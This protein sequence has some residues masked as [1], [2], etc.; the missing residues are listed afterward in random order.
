M[1]NSHSPTRPLTSLD[2]MGEGWE[3]LLAS[4]SD[5][6]AGLQIGP[7]KLKRPLGEGGMGMVWLAEQ[8][9]PL[10]REVAIK[11]MRQERRGALDEAYFEVERQALARLSHR[12]IA[13]IH[14][15]GRLP[16][17]TLFFAMEYVPGVP[18][19]DFVRAERPALAELARLFVEICLGVQHAH[20]RG[21]IHRDLKPA[22]LL[23]QRVEGVAL[24][25][26]IDF[27]IATSLSPAGT[28]GSAT[29]A[30]TRAYMS[31]EQH[32][33]DSA[34]IDARTDV[35]A[36]GAVLAECLLLSAGIETAVETNSASLREALTLSLGP[37]RLAS[38]VKEL[39]ALPAE[40]RAIA[41]LAMS[42]DREKRYGSAAAMADDLTRWLARKPV[43]AMGASRWYSLRCLVR[44][45]AL[46]STAAIVALLA[47][48]VFA[49]AM[50]VQASRIAREAER[51]NK[52]LA[53]L[54][55]VTDFQN[56]QLLGISTEKVGTRIFNEIRAR[57]RA[58]LVARGLPT[59]SI[60]ATDAEFAA[61]L[62]TVNFTDV[63]R[64]SLDEGIFA[65]G[66][67]NIREKF[68]DQPIVR[69]ELLQ[70]SS[71]A[72]R[73]LGLL[74][75]ARV[76]QEEALALKRQVYTDPHAQIAYSLNE[77]GVLCQAE[78]KPA[79][80][81]AYFREAL[82]MNMAT[83][84][85]DSDAT[86][87]SMLNLAT[88]LQVQA[89]KAEE[90]EQLYRRMIAVQEK[91]L[92]ADDPGVLMARGNYAVM[93]YQAGDYVAAEREFL[94]VLAAHRLSG[95]E[96]LSL[97]A[98][99]NLSGTT[100]AT[101]KIVEAEAYLRE[102][103]AIGS[104]LLGAEHRQVLRYNVSLSTIMSEL[105]R[106]DEAEALLR[107][108]L[109][110][111][112]RTL[113][114]NHL[115][116]LR[117]ELLLGNLLARQDRLIEAELLVRHAYEQYRLQSGSDHPSTLGALADLAEF[118]R[119][120]GQAKAAVAMLRE[121]MADIRRV[122]TGADEARLGSALST[123]GQALASLDGDQNRADAQAMLEESYALF[124]RVRGE[125]HG[126]PRKIARH[127]TEF[128]LARE[129]AEPGAGHAATAAKWQAL[130]DI[131]ATIPSAQ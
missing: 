98:L 11:V 119:K 122:S 25:K 123:L 104:R 46:L 117:N 108:T 83:S 73:D 125:T 27:G 103:I 90:A 96:L 26:I 21:L 92:P 129:A 128:F 41:V 72:M 51:A 112:R 19:D 53:D 77:I 94:L 61:S 110:V 80:A 118:L 113:P 56:D 111:R 52:A 60:D 1:S 130:R 59:A 37:S 114:E 109:D 29:V 91:K 55:E 9:Q 4:I 47:L 36:L 107:T 45:N 86:F 95:N 76:P 33:P 35:Y 2:P 89:D 10:R 54:R 64:D 67:V 48:G 57:H 12:A 71:M 49:I 28:S 79:D 20:H 24:P 39:S 44:R 87:T 97:N 68:A 69:A 74:K 7:F 22:N 63:A 50:T 99:N 85:E 82:A 38:S 131:Q 93:K 101:G 62:G 14:E 42:E 115:D 124:A 23:V 75:Q 116:I 120:S 40:L 15:A 58:S 34:G 127:L 78:G 121:N 106:T 31:P 43:Y 3:P 81:E 65:R 8:L 13:Q 66:L 5:W 102:A 16:D 18:L 6:K 70:V 84:G 17:G 32:R 105:G 126:D 100:R 88:L 30:G